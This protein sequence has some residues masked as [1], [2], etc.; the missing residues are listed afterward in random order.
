MDRARDKLA[1]TRRGNPADR[2]AGFSTGR[3]MPSVHNLG[4]PLSSPVSFDT[5]TK[6]D[7]YWRQLLRDQSMPYCLAR[8]QKVHVNE[9][10][11]DVVVVNFQLTLIRNTQLW[12][13]L[14]VVALIIAVIVD[15]ATRKVTKIH[16]QKVLIKVGD[17]WKVFNGEWQGYDELN[18]GWLRA[19]DARVPEGYQ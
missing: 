12:M 11:E 13:L 15:L 19:G 17:E 5:D 10:A 4:H 6:F 3:V 1:I 2:K 16:M 7:G 14:I 8:V 18:H 9:V